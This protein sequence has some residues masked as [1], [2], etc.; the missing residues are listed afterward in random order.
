[1]NVLFICKHN[2]FRSKVAE[3][4]F[5]KQVSSGEV[6]SAGINLDLPY[7]APLVKKVLREQGLEADNTPRM[8]TPELIDWA[9]KIIIVADNV[10]A[11]L[12]PESKVERWAVTDCNQDDED[13][14]RLRVR[15]IDKRVNA[16]A[17]RI[18]K[19]P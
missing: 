13:G 11:A 6:K 9:D 18:R 17:R 16:L 1:M 14:I 2:R 15:D 10:D 4:L 5:R 3:A 19:R 8:I 7:V 12:F